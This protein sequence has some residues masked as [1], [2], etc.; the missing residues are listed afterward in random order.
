MQCK[1]QRERTTIPNLGL[2]ISPNHSPT[3]CRPRPSSPPLGFRCR[4]PGPGP[5]PSRPSIAIDGCRGPRPAPPARQR[6]QLWA[7]P[8]AAVSLV[9]IHPRLYGCLMP[10]VFFHVVLPVAVAVPGSACPVRL[11]SGPRGMPARLS[12]TRC[13]A[14]FHERHEMRESTLSLLF[15]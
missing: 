10:S 9:T 1:H 12:A 13:R 2:R 8:S 15:S 5:G 7:R 6:T 11:T 4:R 3:R 14:W